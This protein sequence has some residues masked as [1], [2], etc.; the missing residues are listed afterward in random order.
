[1]VVEIL[2]VDVEEEVVVMVA[3]IVAAVDIMAAM[4]AQI[5][6]SVNCVARRAT[7]V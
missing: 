1:M 6:P 3:S 2:M 4:G 7:R 5:A